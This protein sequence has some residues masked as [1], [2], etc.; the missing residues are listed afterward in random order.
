M[1]ST[2][3]A[4]Q[5]WHVR[6]APALEECM[7]FELIPLQHVC[8]AIHQVLQTFTIHTEG[9]QNTIFALP[10]RQYSDS[11]Q[12]SSPVRPPMRCSEEHD[13]IRRR[14]DGL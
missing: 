8:E 13:G 1:Q 9:L 7:D 11:L 3:L 10:S 14:E 12:E 4:I 6:Y 5:A 2:D